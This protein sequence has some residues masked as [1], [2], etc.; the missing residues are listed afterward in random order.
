MSAL[1]KKTIKCQSCEVKCDVIIRDANYE[2][3]AVDI[4]Y[5]PICSIELNE[6]ESEYED[7]DWEMGS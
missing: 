2:L 6:M 5:C 4:N 7:D 3:D 1:V